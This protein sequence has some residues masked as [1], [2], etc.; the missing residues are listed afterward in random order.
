MNGTGLGASGRGSGFVEPIG[1]DGRMRRS[2]AV[3]QHLHQPQIV[4]M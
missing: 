2:Q 4:G 1:K 3:G